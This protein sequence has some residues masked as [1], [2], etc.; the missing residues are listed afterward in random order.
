MKDNLFEKAKMPT[1]VGTRLSIQLLNH[2]TL[3][4]LSACS[5][6]ACAGEADRFSAVKASVSRGWE[7][8]ATV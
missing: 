3:L 1:D 5:A 6:P 7:V 2:S 8:C 4:L